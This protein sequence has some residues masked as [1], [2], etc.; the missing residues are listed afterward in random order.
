MWNPPVCELLRPQLTRGVASGVTR[1]RNG[2]GKTTTMKILTGEI[3]ATSGS[4][5]LGGLDITEEQQSVRRLIG[6]T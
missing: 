6:S 5:Y 3:L 4:A 2:A 1:C